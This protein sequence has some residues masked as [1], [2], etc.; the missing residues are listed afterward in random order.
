MRARWMPTAAASAPA[1]R[2]PPSPSPSTAVVLT[3]RKIRWMPAP[4]A[5]T[6]QTCQ[7]RVG[8]T[9]GR[10]LSWLL[11]CAGAVKSATVMVLLQQMAAFISK[12][13]AS[14]FSCAKRKT[15]FIFLSKVSRRTQVME[16]A[17]ADTLL[18]AL[19]L[20]CTRSCANRAK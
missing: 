12:C 16:A 6:C 5:T 4:A 19:Q 17:L 11:N 14:A 18:D 3:A 7:I 13:C 20:V 2:R 1:P 15:A 9:P 10:H 8:H